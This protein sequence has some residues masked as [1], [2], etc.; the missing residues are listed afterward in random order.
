M[1]NCFFFFDSSQGSRKGC[2]LLPISLQVFINDMLEVVEAA[3]QRVKLGE[4]EVSGL[5]FVGDLVEISDT[6]EELQKQTDLSMEYDRKWRLSANVKK[7]A[8]M[9][10]NY[11]KVKEVNFRWKWGDKDL[12]RIDQYTCVGVE[13]SD[14]CMW[15]VHMKKKLIKGRPG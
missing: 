6:L 9:V 5:L 14:D 3:S 13:F 10:C 7:C 11:G 8:A 2:A 15:D 4:S 1:G 12:P